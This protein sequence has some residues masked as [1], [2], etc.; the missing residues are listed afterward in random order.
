L[1]PRTYILPGEAWAAPLLL[2]GFGPAVDASWRP[3]SGKA[4][5]LLEGEG[6]R[7]YLGLYFWPESCNH[8]LTV[9]GHTFQVSTPG[10]HYFK[11]PSATGDIEITLSPAPSKPPAF[12]VIGLSEL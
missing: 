6:S 1:P 3:M 10:D 8:Q 2:E 11:C 7:L 5:V 12:R 4:R 9:A